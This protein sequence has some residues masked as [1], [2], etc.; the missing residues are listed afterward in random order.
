MNLDALLTCSATGSVTVSNDGDRPL[1]VTAANIV[2]DSFMTC[3][4]FTRSWGGPRTLSPGSSLSIT[5]TYTATSECFDYV[6]IDSDWNTL[7]IMSNDSSDPDYAVELNGAA[8][9]LF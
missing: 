4:N 5:V 6:D 1:N 7:H 2:N 9:C 3:G 8:S